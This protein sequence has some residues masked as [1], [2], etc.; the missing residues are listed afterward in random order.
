MKL[1]VLVLGAGGQLGQAMT[2]GLG[3]RHEVVPRTRAD[4]DV[5]SAE[6]VRSV[7]ASIC[8]D[9]IVNCSAYTN[10]DGAETEPLPALATNAWAVRSLA[11]AAADYEATLVHFS[12]D[13]VFDGAADRP[14]GEEDE[15]NPRGI[16]AVS[17]LLGEWFAADAPRHY[18]LRVES[19]FGGPHARSSV[20]RLLDGILSG[21]DVR[22]FRDR[23]VSPSFVDDVV[24][25]TNELLRLDA[26][27]GLYHC[28][29]SGWATWSEVARELA[30]IVGKADARITDVSMDDIPMAAARPAFAA[31][32][33]DKL[34]RA[35]IA[36][37]PWQDAL[38]R[39][40]HARAVD[41]GVQGA[42]GSTSEGSTME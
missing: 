37:P 36:M 4:V 11:R 28:V 8:P 6:A 25:A 26:P 21:G 31:L 1:L 39:Y 10:V 17:K 16:Y 13:F 41:R 27:G 9:V 20:D 15:P 24:A 30:A 42:E 40:V 12:T 22:A 34:S 38:R 5:A 3:G 29:N 35:G 14:Y 7:V 19:L 2:D 33:N 23:T 32:S 18:V